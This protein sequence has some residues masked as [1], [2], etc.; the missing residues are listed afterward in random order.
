MKSQIISRDNKGFTLIEMVIVLA[1]ITIVGGLGLYFGLD[2]LRGY[3]F[4]SDRDVLVSVLQHA[5]SEAISN[6]CRGEGC[7]DGKPHGVFI[8]PP[9]HPKSY[10]IFQGTD[11]ANR[12]IDY[13]VV[14]DA[15]SSTSFSGI[16][17]IVFERLSGN[18]ITIG[19][20]NLVDDRNHTST[21]SISSMGQILWTN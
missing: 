5:R 12:D 13:D 11:Y 3:S 2:S 19:D 14:I 6:I 20:I 8:R 10:V 18:A 1:L 7:T 4:H 21:I 9:E 17:E 15:S 16:N